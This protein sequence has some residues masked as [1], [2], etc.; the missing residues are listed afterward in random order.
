[1]GR[2]QASEEDGRGGGGVY[3]AQG[4]AGSGRAPRHSGD[5][6]GHCT[7]GAHP[8]GVQALPQPDKL[9]T[10]KKTSL[11]AVKRKSPRTGKPGAAN[12]LGATAPVPL[13]L[14]AAQGRGLGCE[15]RSSGEI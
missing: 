9:D 10:G 3:P 7:L 14:G 15:L 11:V 1:M 4:R 12:G 6:W 5:V 2:W 13:G 8:G